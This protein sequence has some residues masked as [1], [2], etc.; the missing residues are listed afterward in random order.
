[1]SSQHER[2]ETAERQAVIE[3]YGTLLGEMYPEVRATGT[4][5]VH[6]QS[7]VA[8][9]REAR[10]AE[11]APGWT[12]DKIEELRRIVGMRDKTIADLRA[13]GQGHVDE[14]TQCVLETVEDLV[15]ADSLEEVLAAITKLRA[16]E[17]RRQVAKV[18]RSRREFDAEVLRAMRSES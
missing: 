18:T 14:E 15:G 9:I 7:C 2:Y 4:G 17:A 11:A 8:Q 5:L 10:A 16:D 1:M 12:Y 13:A 3:L 6:A